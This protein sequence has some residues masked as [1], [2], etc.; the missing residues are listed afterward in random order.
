MFILDFRGSMYDIY[1]FHSISFKGRLKKLIFLNV[2]QSKERLSNLIKNQ[3][4]MIFDDHNKPDRRLKEE[5]IWFWSKAKNPSVQVGDAGLILGLE[6]SFGEEN[7]NPLQYSA[8]EIL[9]TKKPGGLQSLG[10]QRVVH[11][12]ATKQQQQNSS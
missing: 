1:V 2:A 11:N 9:W 4:D 6:R 7:D 8:G 10:L 5:S 12:L 3:M